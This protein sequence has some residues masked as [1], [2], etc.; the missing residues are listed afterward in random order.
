MN[1]Q[2]AITFLPVAGLALVLGLGLP[3]AAAAQEDGSFSGRIVLGFRSV[4]VNG[5]ETKYREDLNVSDGPRLMDLDIDF[6]PAGLARSFVDRIQLDVNDFGSDPFESV[7]L[8]VDKFGQFRFTYDR[9][10]SEY[11]Y[12]DI[13]L[14]HDLADVR[15]SSGGDFHHFDFERVRDRAKLD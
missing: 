15:L 11:F 3:P 14:P 12:Q 8:A 1:R 6:T 7:R 2:T 13:I 9:W 5:T 10:E 4:D